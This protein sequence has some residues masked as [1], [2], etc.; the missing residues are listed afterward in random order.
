[1]S[2]RLIDFIVQCR[3]YIEFIERE[4]GVKSEFPFCLSNGVRVKILYF[5]IAMEDTLKLAFHPSFGAKFPLLI[6]L[7]S[8]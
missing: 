6:L 5:G 2:Q 3:A 7:L 1:M 8:S 4:V